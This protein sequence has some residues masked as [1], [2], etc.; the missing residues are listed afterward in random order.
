MVAGPDDDECTEKLSCSFCG[1]SQDEVATLIAGPESNICD[2][3]VDTLGDIVADARARADATA[4]GEG[5]ARP[6]S[7]R[8]TNQCSLCRMPVAAAD[9]VEIAGRGSVC[10]PCI[11]AVQALDLRKGDP[12]A[13][14]Q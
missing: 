11:A 8:W 5:A 3:C 10:S 1:K 6:G 7:R 4:A 2:E 12:G 13:G 14:G 9:L